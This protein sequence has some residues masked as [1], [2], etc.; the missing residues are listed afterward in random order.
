MGCVCIFISACVY[1]CVCCE[2]LI[3]AS[4]CHNCITGHMKIYA[5][6]EMA[7]RL[8]FL[9]KLHVFRSLCNW[10]IPGFWECFI[11]TKI[12]YIKSRILARTEIIKKQNLETQF[13]S[14]IYYILLVNITYL[15]NGEYVKWKS[16]INPGQAFTNDHDGYHHMK[17]C[18]FHNNIKNKSLLKIIW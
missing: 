15:F 2:C 5:C 13:G 17:V 4:L 3:M 18:V 16:W 7:W 11:D 12:L 8:L 6:I 10:I 9:I 14:L 1:I